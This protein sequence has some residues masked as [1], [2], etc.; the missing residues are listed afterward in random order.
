M[1]IGADVLILSSFG[2]IGPIFAIFILGLEG[3]SIVAAGAATTIFLVVRASIQLPLSKYFIDRQKHKTKFLLL[4]FFIVLTVPF[5]Y[6]SSKHVY[7]IFLAQAVY[8]VGTAF[9]YPTVFS[10]FTSYMDKRH[11]S[12]DYAI[13]NTGVCLGTALSAFVGAKVAESFGFSVVFFFVGGLALIGFMI[14][15]I[16]HTLEE[17]DFRKAERK[18]KK[19]ERERRRRRKLL[20]KTKKRKYRATL[21]RRKIL[22]KTRIKNLKEK[23]KRSKAIKEGIEKAKR[24]K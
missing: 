4:G 21:K 5:I 18:R 15:I 24:I 7:T 1:L 8:G 23:A 16:L 3:G 14:L 20:E 9:A 22:K 12:F 17:A 19:L 13:N 11:R 6:L 10:L 2:L